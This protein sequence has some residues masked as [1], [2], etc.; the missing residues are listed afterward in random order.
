MQPEQLRQELL[1]RQISRVDFLRYSSNEPWVIYAV[2]INDSRAVLVD[3]QQGQMQ[4]LLSQRKELVYPNGVYSW[5]VE[6]DAMRRRSPPI[7][8]LCLYIKTSASCKA[9]SKLCP[10]SCTQPTATSGN[11]L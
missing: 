3:L 6:S 11:H 8:R 9:M 7:V 5:F 1:E 4:I 10:S 2:Q